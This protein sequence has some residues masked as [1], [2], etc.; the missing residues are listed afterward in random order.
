[1]IKD[2][3]YEIFPALIDELNEGWVWIREQELEK[4][5][6]R[7]PIAHI[8]KVTDMG[9][10]RAIY[11][12]VLYAEKIHLFKMEE[13]ME[14]ERTRLRN[15]LSSDPGLQSSIK[16]LDGGL[17]GLKCYNISL[18][19]PKIF[20]S[21]WYRCCLGIEKI[22]DLPNRRVMLRVRYNHFP[23]RWWY[24]LRACLQHPQVSVFVA[25][26]L[27]I[28]GTALGFIGMGV[29]LA[30]LPK[31]WQMQLLPWITDKI[32]IDFFNRFDIV[33]WLHWL[34]VVLF[35]IGIV[36][37]GYGLYAFQERSRRS[38]SSSARSP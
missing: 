37:F 38:R 14:T 10:K 12:E 11:C 24:Q 25:T 21:E 29:G 16:L 20:M 9:A 1:M 33:N 34:G 15:H 28:I 27:A 2:K 23:L 5:R 32:F 8:E 35:V 19:P 17:S 13:N 36:V 7:R 22:G 31:D 30:A 6:G 4:R 18:D 26:V 3:E